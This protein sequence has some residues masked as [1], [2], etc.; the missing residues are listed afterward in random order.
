MHPYPQSLAEPPNHKLG[1]RPS[2]V[3]HQSRSALLLVKVMVV[4]VMV[5]MVV[6]YQELLVMAVLVVHI[7]L[8]VSGAG[9]ASA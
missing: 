4:M 6:V 9:P 2:E 5:V 1:I 7:M 8:I 3:H